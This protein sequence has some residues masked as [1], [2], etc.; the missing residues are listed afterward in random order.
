MQTMAKTNMQTMVKTNKPTS[1]KINT[2]T[3][4]QRSAV[5]DKKIKR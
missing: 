1:D 5:A 2:R 4:G 3:E